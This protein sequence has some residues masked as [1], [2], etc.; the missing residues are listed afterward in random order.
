MKPRWAKPTD[1]LSQYEMH[2]CRWISENTY[3]T[4]WKVL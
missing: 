4:I 1:F 2:W 3:T